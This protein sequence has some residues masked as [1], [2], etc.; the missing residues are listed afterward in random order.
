MLSRY[1]FLLNLMIVSKMCYLISLNSR[2]F[3]NFNFLF[4][5]EQIGQ[6]LMLVPVWSLELNQANMKSMSKSRIEFDVG[7]GL[8]LKLSEYEMHER[9]LRVKTK[10]RP[11]LASNS[12]CHNAP[13]CTL[14]YL[15]NLLLPRSIYISSSK[16]SN[17]NFS[18]IFSIPCT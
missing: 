18:S 2:S 8:E 17:L 14:F 4:D 12:Q 10:N 11:I 7:V 16:S 9:Q 5:Y 13:K 3:H 15:N 6:K 1:I